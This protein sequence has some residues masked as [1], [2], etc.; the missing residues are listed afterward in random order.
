MNMPRKSLPNPFTLFLAILSLC[1][2][3]IC[4]TL[5]L[6]I[7]PRMLPIGFGWLALLFLLF[8]AHIVDKYFRAYRLRRRISLARQRGLILCP[9]C[10]YDLRATPTHCSECG[11]ANRDAA[12]SPSSPSPSN[13]EEKAR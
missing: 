8:P 5:N 1:L 6:M 3:I 11:A 12:L 9:T 4:F 13:S 7:I 2:S 10:G